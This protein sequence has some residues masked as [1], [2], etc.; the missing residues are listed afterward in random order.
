MTICI[1]AIGKNSNEEFIIF[2]TDHMVTTPSGQFEQSIEKF[3]AINKTTVAMF[4]GNALLFQKIMDK[5]DSKLKDSEYGKLADAIHTSMRD[6]RIETFEKEV[7]G[8]YNLKLPEL[9]AFLDKKI[10]NNYVNDML[11]KL[12]A[13]SLGS[14]ILTVGFKD[15]SAQITLIT[16]YIKVEHRDLNFGA[17]GSG[18]AQAINT[19][20]FQKHSK[21]NDLGTTLYNVYKAKRN[22][23]VAVGV[24]KETDM[25]ILH[26]K[27]GL[28]RIKPSYE[29]QLDEVYSK[30]L[31]YGKS[32]SVTK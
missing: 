11:F 5:L 15:Q 16:E 27:K 6:V 1:A 22:A 21:D 8:I 3:K 32:S 4:S 9:K 2:A 14:A 17:I 13:Y 25:Y 12:S 18:E 26:Q 20:M 31:Q 19:L 23:E 7:L 24:G 30:E 28:I 29:K 10:E